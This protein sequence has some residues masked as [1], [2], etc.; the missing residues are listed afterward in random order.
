MF[1]F[2][3]TKPAKKVDLARAANLLAA[4][5]LAAKPKISYPSA[6]SFATNQFGCRVFW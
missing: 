3:R 1:P 4:E 5:A 6:G 2:D